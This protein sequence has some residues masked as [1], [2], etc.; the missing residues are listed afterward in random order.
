[1]NSPAEA[2]DDSSQPKDLLRLKLIEL[3]HAAHLRALFDLEAQHAALKAKMAEGN[4]GEE[5]A[6]PTAEPFWTGVTDDGRPWMSQLLESVPEPQPA[7]APALSE[8]AALTPAPS[9]AAAELLLADFKT[10]V[11]LVDFADAL[12]REA[13]DETVKGNARI[14]RDCADATVDWMK[15]AE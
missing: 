11:E 13:V 14:L 15:D 2:N 4:G 8:Q 9:T 6:P 10:H 1:M 3:K 12:L 7:A 5:G